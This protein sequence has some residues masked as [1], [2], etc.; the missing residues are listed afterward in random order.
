VP[1]L[2]TGFKSLTAAVE[3]VRLHARKQIVNTHNV[4]YEKLYINR[5]STTLLGKPLYAV[6]NK[7][8]SATL[9]MLDGDGNVIK[10]YPDNVRWNDVE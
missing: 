9:L 10:H 1:N 3:H 7:K 6:A 2:L 5:Y 8:T 4:P